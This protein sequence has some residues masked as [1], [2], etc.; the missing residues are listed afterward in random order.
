MRYSRSL[1]MPDHQPQDPGENS[2]WAATA[3]AAPAC[4]RLR[5]AVRADVLVVGGGYTGLSSAL[6]LAAAGVDVVLLEGRRLGYGGS[7][8]N[9]GLVNAGVW[10]NPRHVVEQL[11][12]ARAERFNLA[13]RDSPALVFGLVERHAME[14]D[15]RRVGT[16]QIAHSA[17]ALKD[18]EERCRQIQGLGAAVEMIDASTAARLSGSPLYRHGG[19][20]DP[21]AG[22]IHPLAYVR[23]LAHA[24]LAAGARIFEESAILGLEQTAQGWRATTAAGEVSAERVILATNAYADANSS[25]VREATVPVYIFQCASEPLNPELAAELIPERHGLWD[26]QPLMTSS[27][28]DGAGRLIMSSAGQLAGYQRPVREDWMRRNRERLFPQTRGLRWEYRWS[29][30]VGVTDSRILRVQL[31]APGVYA[32]AGYNGRG[33]GPGTVIGKHLAELIAGGSEQDF[34]F[35][36]QPLHRE[37]WRGLRAAGYSYGTLALQFVD[38]R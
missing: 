5:E 14:C 12:T 6:H 9:A 21:G 11:G 26:T 27:R 22:T 29:G 20:V 30:R 32:P 4:E 37:S 36:L 31:L 13:L 3:I 38:R 8:R 16:I 34:P 18:L 28:I 1:H 17:A 10:R 15:A 24:A 33:I 35:P 23:S 25:R 7:G 2:L 19:I